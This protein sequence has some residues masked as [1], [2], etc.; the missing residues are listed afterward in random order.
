MSGTVCSERP[1]PIYK[2]KKPNPTDAG[3]KSVVKNGES[4]RCMVPPMTLNRASLVGGFFPNPDFSV[5]KSWRCFGGGLAEGSGVVNE[6]SHDV[7][8]P[9]DDTYSSLVVSGCSWE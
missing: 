3:D 2:K 9:L 5:G 7:K 6:R 1:P 4:A 8:L